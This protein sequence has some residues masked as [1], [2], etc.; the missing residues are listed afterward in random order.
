MAICPFPSRNAMISS[1]A[2]SMH[3]LRMLSYCR[4]IGQASTHLGNGVVEELWRWRRILREVLDTHLGGG[5]VLGVVSLPSQEL[6]DTVCHKA[7]H[8]GEKTSSTFCHIHSVQSCKSRVS[9]LSVFPLHCPSQLR[10]SPCHDTGK[11]RMENPH[12]EMSTESR[13][14][15]NDSHPL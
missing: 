10:H 5:N 6:A 14:W 3:L 12:L 15:Y 4:V 2:R 8:H 9:S 7:S 11:E 1:N 13:S